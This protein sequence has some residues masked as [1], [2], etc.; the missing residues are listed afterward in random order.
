MA[1][2]FEL[3]PKLI[4]VAAEHL[5]L[6]G[7]ITVYLNGKRGPNN[8]VCHTSVVEGRWRHKIMLKSYCGSRQASTTLWHE[9]CHASQIE[10]LGNV[11]RWNALYRR[12]NRLYGYDHNKYEVD[13]RALAEAMSGTCIVVPKNAILE[14]STVLE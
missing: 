14:P 9:L 2:W 3:D 11:E 10:Q 4:C 13:A 6:R 12:E 8:G 1:E 7:R 5:N